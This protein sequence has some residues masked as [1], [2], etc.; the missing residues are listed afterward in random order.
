MGNEHAFESE[1]A[2]SFFF[3]SRRRHTRL[4][5]DWSSDVCSSDLGD[6]NL[7]IGQAEQAIIELNKLLDAN[8]KIPGLERFKK[9]VIC[10]LVGLA[11]YY[12][13]KVSSNRNI[14]EGGL[15]GLKRPLGLLKEAELL[16]VKYWGD[17]SSLD[18]IA[19][20]IAAFIKAADIYFKK[21]ETDSAQQVIEKHIYPFFADESYYG[22]V[23]YDTAATLS[24]L[25]NKFKK[26]PGID[27]IEAALH[28][29]YE[30]PDER[31]DLGSLDIQKVSNEIKGRRNIE[32]PGYI[33]Y[34]KIINEGAE[35]LRQEM[36]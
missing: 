1:A 7:T 10:G 5:S 26:N 8:P 2:C 19:V 11:K 32:D 13:N 4:V 29:F 21:G 6:L 16:S 18:S 12:Q 14:K 24:V 23:R 30:Y 17:N 25:L 28:E 3:S 35:L 15:E 9:L 22:R 36:T 31:F 27:K 20:I 33:D 34:L